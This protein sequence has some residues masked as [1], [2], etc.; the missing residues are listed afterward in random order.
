MKETSSFATAK[1]AYEALSRG[2]Y[3]ES[4]ENGDPLPMISNFHRDGVVVVISSSRERANDLAEELSE[5]YQQ[6]ATVRAISSLF[7]TVVQLARRGIAGLLLDGDHPIYFMNR[8]SEMNRSLP[9]VGAIGLRK[10]NDDLPERLNFR[11]YLHFGVR[12]ELNL[13]H[14]SLVRWHNF[15]ALDAMSVKWILGERPLPETLLPYTIRSDA[16]VA[17]VVETG[18]PGVLT[19]FH[20]GATLLGP[21]VSDMGAVPIFS[22]EV[23]AT[24]YGQIHHFLENHGGGW[25]PSDNHSVQPI[26]G[27]LVNFLNEIYADHSSVVDIGLNPC[28]HRFR[29]GYFFYR[30]GCWFLRTLAGVFKITERRFERRDDVL[31]PKGDD[32]VGGRNGDYELIEGMTTLVQHPFKRLLGATQSAVPADEAEQI[33]AED[34][35]IDLEEGYSEPEIREVTSD[36]FLLDGFDKIT[37]DDL[38]FLMTAGEWDGPLV[39]S[40]IVQASSWLLVNFLESDEEIRTTGAATCHGPYHPGS[41]DPDA[42]ATKSNALRQAVCTF[43]VD[44]LRTGYRPIHSWHLKRLFQDVSAVLEI[45]TAGY[46]AD[47]VTYDE[48]FL[49]GLDAGL[50]EDESPLAL[51]FKKI[52]AKLDSRPLM[53]TAVIADLRRY[54]GQAMDLLSQSSIQILCAAIEELKRV[55][56]RPAYDYAGVSMKICK[57]FERELK[58]QLF[59]SWCKEVRSGGK[60]GVKQ[61]ERE[62]GAFQDDRTGCTALEFLAKRQ[63]IE[64][65][66]MRYM[67]RAV[68]EGS[69][70]PVI[71]NLSGFVD[72][73]EGREWLLSKSLDES[74]ERISSRYRNGG[75]H[76]HL[77]DY[78][79][80]SEALDY[81]VIGKDAVLPTLLRSLVKKG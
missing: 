70:H 21:Y 35:A 41:G 38:S 68:A 78:G 13:E 14:I 71:K 74:L 16:Q 42:E 73:F 12:G 34:L 5:A 65:G 53:D 36:S 48:E 23:W 58:H 10:L 59:D 50:D 67:L 77:V 8:L 40:D 60:N 6:K 2:F 20:D 54:L 52:K 80:C 45:T 44:A 72:S 11:D 3:I 43:L 39:F 24:F 32:D 37:G 62:A 18:C 56:N 57:T 79:L 17:E 49:A 28:C 75:L 4:E 33:I 15:R 76:E 46:V 47:L 7:D 26:K 29:Q 31:P 30:D 9:T 19:L 69:E 1:D 66:S 55:G 61:L 51:R 64:L 22:G 27:E 81:L 25:V 63:K